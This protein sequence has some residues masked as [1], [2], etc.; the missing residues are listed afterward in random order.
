MIPKTTHLMSG[1]WDLDVGVWTLELLMISSQW[2]G[3]GASRPKAG[4]WGRLMSH[5][6]FLNPPST[7]WKLRVTYDGIQMHGRHPSTLKVW[8]EKDPRHAGDSTHSDSGRVFRRSRRRRSRRLDVERSARKRVWHYGSMAPN[9]I[10]KAT[11]AG[12]FT[13]ARKQRTTQ[14]SGAIT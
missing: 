3:H 8:R 1:R 2:E 14:C 12:T 9:F 11:Q 6:P 5:P 4:G 13:L 7:S 10:R